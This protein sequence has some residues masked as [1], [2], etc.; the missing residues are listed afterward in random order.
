MLRKI[1]KSWK[2]DWFEEDLADAAAGDVRAKV[3][4]AGAYV[5]GDVTPKDYER[6]KILLTE[7]LENST[8]LVRFD[9]AKW[10]L[11]IRDSKFFEII[12]DDVNKGHPPALYLMGV[13]FHKNYLGTTNLKK[14]LQYYDRAALSGHLSSKALALHIRYAGLRKA[15]VFPAILWIA[16]K[17]GY[18]ML[19][20]PN[21]V[22]ALH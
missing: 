11:F 6:A 20:D 19:K 1:W 5:N 9:C 18:L 8:P 17:L 22:N 3:N 15:I 4:L 16:L 21:H 14:A 10:Y 12:S 2:K 13:S 7:A